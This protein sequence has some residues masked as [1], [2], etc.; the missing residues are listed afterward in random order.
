MQGPGGTAGPDGRGLKDRFEIVVIVLI[1]TPE[2]H[3]FR[4][5]SELTFH[6]AIFSAAVRLDRQA[7]LGPELPLAPEPVRRLQ[8]CHQKSGPERADARNLAQQ[9]GRTMFSALGQQ[10]P[11]HHLA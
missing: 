4:R 7:T 3:R 10:I 9:F 6:I 5:A 11:P 2:R 1:E 8:Q